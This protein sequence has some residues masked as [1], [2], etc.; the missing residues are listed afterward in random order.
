MWH[1]SSFAYGTHTH[2]NLSYTVVVW[3]KNQFVALY[4]PRYCIDD[5]FQFSRRVSRNFPTISHFIGHKR[6]VQK[7]KWP[8]VL[9]SRCPE[10]SLGGKTPS[11]NYLHLTWGWT[12][13]LSSLPDSLFR[14]PDMRKEISLSWG[15]EYVLSK[16]VDCSY[17]KKDSLAR[18]L[19]EEIRMSPNVSL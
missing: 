17:E 16:E 10:S 13:C 14:S 19:Y 5:V 1:I 15:K 8:I 18:I 6:S 2:C 9:P 3:V 4:K 11:L 7:A 12:W